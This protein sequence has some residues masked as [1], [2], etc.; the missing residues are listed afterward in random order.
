VCVC[1]CVCVCVGVC[2]RERERVRPPRLPGSMHPDTARSCALL[3]LEAA[4]AM[5]CSRVRLPSSLFLDCQ[6][7]EDSVNLLKGAAKM[8]K[9]TGNLEVF[10]WRGNALQGSL[11]FF[12]FHVS[13]YV[14]LGRYLGRFAE[15]G[16]WNC[17]SR[18]LAKVLVHPFIL[19]HHICLQSNPN[20]WF[21][22]YPKSPY[23]LCSVCNVSG[24]RV[25]MVSCSSRRS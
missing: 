22:H 10:P 12:T 9:S 1:V 25:L 7:I 3:P 20:F 13:A 19:S 14:L 4:S 11:V 8:R 5:A 23:V 6:W 18:R 16:K 21:I 2:E 15:R 24:I 17:P